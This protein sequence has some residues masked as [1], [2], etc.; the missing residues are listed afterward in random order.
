MWGTV[1]GVELSHSHMLP[2]LIQLFMTEF[3]LFF[4]KALNDLGDKWSNR[5]FRH[6]QVVHP[7]L[8]VNLEYTPAKTDKQRFVQNLWKAQALAR[9]RL[10]APARRSTHISHSEALP[11]AFVSNNNVKLEGPHSSA[12]QAISFWNMWERAA[13]TAHLNKV[14]N[15]AAKLETAEFNT[16][17]RQSEQSRIA[18][19]RDRHCG[20]HSRRLTR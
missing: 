9:T 20:I 7:P 12:G 15:L 10:S 14:N 16:L 17:A 2:R 11:I 1:V 3:E 8:P 4:E 18:C 5:P 6:Y 13:W 19:R